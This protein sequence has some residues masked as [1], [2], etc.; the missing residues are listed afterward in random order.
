MSSDELGV[1][2]ESATK[3]GRRT[4]SRSS[5]PSKRR[6]AGVETMP[7]SL[8]RDFERCFSRK[9]MERTTG[10][11][12]SSDDDDDDDAT[13]KSDCASKVSLFAMAIA[14]AGLR[15]WAETAAAAAEAATTAAVDSGGPNT[16]SACSMS[17]SMT[18]VWCTVSTSDE[19]VALPSDVRNNVG[20]NT[21]P[22]LEAGMLLVSCSVAT[23]FKWCMRKASVA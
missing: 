3:P 19:R 6:S 9:E 7:G 5:N 4:S 18:R 14:A 1:L 17:S 11:F 21:I 22:R 23:R 8:S 10:T 20:P 16:D 2:T 12:E 15:G 13:A